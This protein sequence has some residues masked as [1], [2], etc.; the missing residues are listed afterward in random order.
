MNELNSKSKAICIL[1]MHRSGT[2]TV[3]RLINLLGAYLGE[4]TDLMLPGSDNPEGYW[5]RNDVVLLHDR[6]LNHLKRSWDSSLPLPD[7]WYQREDV[8]PF[9]DEL[10]ELVKKNFNGQGLWA[11]KDPRTT[12]L[13]DIWKDVLN[14]LGV[15]LK[16]VICVRN[17]LD[18][19]RSLEKRNGFP[20]DKSF[21]IWFNYNIEVLK[22][23]NGLPRSF[24]TYDNLLKNWA[25]ELNRCAS[26]LDIPWPADDSELTEKVNTFIRPTLRHSASTTDELIKES[27]VQ[28]VIKLYE[29]LKETSPELQIPNTAFTAKIE[30]SAKEF[31]AYARFYQYDMERLWNL[32]RQIIEKN[33]QLAD[34][35]KQLADKDRQ[36]ADQCADQNRQ[37][38]EK[39]MALADLEA[40]VEAF[41][42]SLSWK[43]TAPARRILSAVNIKD[44][45][46]DRI[47]HRLNKIALPDIKIKRDWVE[48]PV[49]VIIP[50]KNAGA[51]FTS[52]LSKIAE[53]K[54][55]KSVRLVIIDSGSQDNTVNLSKSY[56]ATVI[57]I[58]PKDFNHGKTR[59][60]AAQS[61]QDCK[62][63]VFITQ[64]AIPIG[65]YWLCDL[66]NSFKF[67][68]HIVATTGKQ[69]PR[70]DA[71]LF[72]R[73]NMYNH[74]K[75]LNFD[76]NE[77]IYSSN[78]DKFSYLQK[79]RVTQLDNV[80]SA[81][82]TEY[83]FKT[84]FKDVRFAED[85]E[86]GCGIIK[87]GFKLAYL[88]DVAVVHSHNRDAAYILKRSYVESTTL[89]DILEY[90]PARP[91][92]HSFESLLQDITDLYLAI[93][94]A[95]SLVNL[96]T[97]FSSFKEELSK[98]DIK[99][100]EAN[101]A[102]SSLEKLLSELNKSN[103]LQKSSPYLKKN[104]S[105]LTAFLGAV[106]SFEKYLKGNNLEIT[107]KEF[108]DCLF[109]IF[110]SVSGSVIGDYA[111]HHPNKIIDEILSKNI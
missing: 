15:E 32:E 100:K 73:W 83:F 9:R 23:T 53:Q 44:Y 16:C 103:V 58:N 4:E 21:G 111:Y 30:S 5:E 86:F 74:Y 70:E 11:W 14:E 26:E 46:I 84:L 6:I 22:A 92:I 64:D 94:I 68:P 106:E 47:K 65:E 56:G 110:G 19:A 97:P 45:Y 1:G 34:K 69:E 29:L 43:I 10:V 12:I 61:A 71:D 78:F 39:D 48:D 67:D 62:Y 49:A 105:C 8:K 38:T 72:A 17:P 27:A 7:K 55:I 24:I 60:L 40:Q 108:Q 50:T 90:S 54:F 37:I 13:L 25:V 51:E 35:D 81:Y 98:I 3:S 63:L 41:K 89:P 80:C 31:S 76:R 28:P 79:R 57:E 2:S 88:N 18:V 107:E 77:I 96:K 33:K 52:T 95:L 87:H 42:N 102:D 75:F 20:Y 104:N 85:I 36:L 66:I 59:N 109:K 99:D 93:K 101:I 82:E 91:N